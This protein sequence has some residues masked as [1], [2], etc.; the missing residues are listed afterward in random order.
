MWT[1]LLSALAPPPTT[2][3][4]LAALGL[5]DAPWT[6]AVFAA[7]IFAVS[8]A[9]AAIVGLVVFP[10]VLRATDWTDTDLDGKLV[11]AIRKP[12]VLGIV[13][14][15]GF[16]AFAVPLDLTAGEQKVINTV[17]AALAIALGVA[18]TSSVISR[19]LDWY[20][21][22]AETRGKFR[23]D[24]Q[25]QPLV[26]RVSTG[27][28]YGL[29]GLLVLDQLN[30]NISPLIAGLGLG[31]LA[32]GLAIQPTL[33]N[34]FAGTYVMTEG[35]VSPGDYVELE[36]GVAGYVIDVGWRSVRIRTW[37]NNLVVVPNSRFAENILTNYQR[38][39]PAVN[40]YLECGV[41]YDS[42][43]FTVERVS[44]EVM[45]EVME[46]NP[47]DAVPDYGAWFGFDSF[48]DSNVNFWL[49][50]QS[51]DRLASF[52][53][54]TELIQRLHRR[55]N[56]EGIVINYPVRTIQLPK[57]LE[58]DGLAGGMAGLAGAREEQPR[59]SPSRGLGARPDADELGPQAPDGGPE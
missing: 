33:S 57:E 3:S 46:A 28:V 22:T 20:V 39:I 19:T 14:L 31:G 45:D 9:L 53:L 17:T 4:R 30:I 2:A 8:V 47:Q 35:A 42:D 26:R 38:P 58:L 10:L 1:P 34:L 24:P 12:I 15:G 37:G 54:R 51:R 13:L 11:L 5:G 59:V 23:L 43:L 49:F 52:R 6:T 56:D 36:G 27:I 32:L 16:L 41:S 7:S 48:G 29:G 55:L 21:E 44:K 25:L 50:M 18:A 40:V